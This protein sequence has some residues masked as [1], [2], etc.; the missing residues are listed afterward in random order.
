MLRARYPFFH[1]IHCLTLPT[2]I[3]RELIIICFLYVC[4]ADDSKE[5]SW[6]LARDSLELNAILNR[7]ENEEISQLQGKMRHKAKNDAKANE[8]RTNELKDVQ[9]RLRAEFIEVSDFVRD[10]N[11]KEKVAEAKAAKELAAQAEMK[12]EIEK[13]T[14]DIAV[15]TEFK[16]KLGAKFEEFKPFKEVVEGVLAESDLYK[17]KKDLIDR[18]DALRMFCQSHKFKQQMQMNVYFLFFIQ[19]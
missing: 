12:A 13:L 5:P 4:V 1:F 10:C 17:N 6:S 8:Q 3:P 18:C 11:A 2:N 7:R 14:N 15:L 9:L 16:D 19:F